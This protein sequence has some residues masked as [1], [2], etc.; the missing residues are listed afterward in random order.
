MVSPVM[1]GPPHRLLSITSMCSIA[2][3]S[4]LRASM[5]PLLVLYCEADHRRLAAVVMVSKSRARGSWE[6]PA[7]SARVL[8]MTPHQGY[9]S[10]CPPIQT[11]SE[12]Y[13][14]LWGTKPTVLDPSN[15]LDLHTLTL[16]H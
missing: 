14:P 4:G 1:A 8:R 2:G 7:G 16:T 15:L 10:V 9:A 6:P 5:A 3:N 12:H 13:L 11:T